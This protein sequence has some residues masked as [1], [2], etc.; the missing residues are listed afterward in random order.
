VLCSSSLKSRD[1]PVFDTGSLLARLAIINLTHE[2]KGLDTYAYTKEKFVTAKD[3]TSL[4]ILDHNFNEEIHHVA[5]GLKWFKYVCAEL[6]LE[7][8]EQFHLLSRKHFKGKLKPP[9]NVEAR[10]TAGLT[11]EWYMPLT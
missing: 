1:C 6:Q 4:K 5:T 10:N 8:L 11:E 7:P 2:A 3:A 9:F